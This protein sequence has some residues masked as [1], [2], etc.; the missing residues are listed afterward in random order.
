M[1]EIDAYELR[2]IVKQGE[3]TPR[4]LL[5]VSRYPNLSIIDLLKFFR[6]CPVYEYKQVLL[7]WFGFT[8]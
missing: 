7:I 3:P 6:L 4:I 1:N 2:Y 8:A 5:I